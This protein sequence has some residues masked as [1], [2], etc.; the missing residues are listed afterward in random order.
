MRYTKGM[1]VM[2]G[3]SQLP[4]CGAYGPCGPFLQQMLGIALVVGGAGLAMLRL[5]ARRLYD[6]LMRAV[7]NFA[8]SRY[9]ALEK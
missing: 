6:I 9:S 2:C 1:C 3:A 7:R 8:Y 4:V 5:G